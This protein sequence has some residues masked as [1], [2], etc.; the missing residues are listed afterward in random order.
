MKNK[1]FQDLIDLKTEYK[2]YTRF[3]LGKSTKF[4]SYMEWDAHIKDLLITNGSPANMYNLKR[5]CMDVIRSKNDTAPIFWGYLGLSI[6]LVISFS[7]EREKIGL[8]GII[9]LIILMSLIIFFAHK[10][11][12]A[13]R[14][15]HFY[16]DIL[17]II[18]QIDLSPPLH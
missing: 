2:E 7:S 16:Q 14:R 15:K 8:H 3:D 5:Y 17:S 9:C 11:T 18:E 13:S 12:V 1:D 10:S 4:T 6:P